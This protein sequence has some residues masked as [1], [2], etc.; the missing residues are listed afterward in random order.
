M[1]FAGTHVLGDD[2]ADLQ[3]TEADLS[4]LLVQHWGRDATTLSATCGQKA[5]AL[6]FLEGKNVTSPMQHELFFP[7]SLGAVGL[8]HAEDPGGTFEGTQGR[9]LKKTKTPHGYQRRRGSRSFW[10]SLAKTA[11]IPRRREE[12]SGKYSQ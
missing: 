8:I 4:R 2:A 5:A 9:N 12:A 11:S 1:R 6:L 3:Q 7:L 10:A